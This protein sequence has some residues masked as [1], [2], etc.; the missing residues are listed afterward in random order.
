MTDFEKLGLFYLGRVFD[1]DAQRATDDLL[2]YDAADLTTHAL[3]VGMTGSGKTGLG[4]ALLEEAAMD[5][6]P[7]IAI[8]P[9]GDLGNLLLTFPALS[10]GDFRP[11]VDEAAAAREGQ[12]PDQAAMQAATKWTEGLA[13][14]GQSGAR[15]ARL[16]ATADFA[17]YT[18]GHTG[19]RPLALL[20]SLAAPPPALAGDAAAR[21]ER[22]TTAVSGLL[23]LLGL[24]ADPVQSREH[25]LL[26]TILDRAW[27]AGRDLDLPALIAAIQQPDFDRVGVFDLETFY[28]SKDRLGLAMA[29]NHLLASPGFAAW[30]AGE[31]LDIQRLLYTPAG[32]PRLSILSIA[33]LS[34][35]ER[36]FFVTALL[37]ELVA[38]MR[39]QSGTSSLRA[40]LYMDEIAGYFPPSA[41]PP[42]KPPMLTLLK[43]ARAYGIGVVLA[44]Q[45]PVDLDYK[46]LANCGTWFLGRL[47]TE[48][49]K[50]RVIEG[51]ESAGG[52][53]GYDRAKLDTLLSGLG[54]RVFLMRN[55]HENAPVLFQTR[56]TMSYLRGPL[57]LKQLT[58]LAPSAPAPAAPAT[59]APAAATPLPAAPAARP[60]A[61]IGVEQW[62]LRPAAGQTGPFTYRPLLG[63]AGRLH[64]VDAS[65]DVD[66]WMDIGW[67]ADLDPDRQV[68]DWAG[69]TKLESLAKVCDRTPPPAAA[70]T[71]P[72][73]VWSN[74]KML[75]SWQKM[76]ADHLYQTFTLDLPACPALKLTAHAGESEG[77]FRARL[78]LAL[79]E[80]RDAAVIHLRAKYAPK[81]AMIEERIRRAAERVERER[82]QVSQQKMQTAISVGATILGALLGRKTLSTGNIGRATTSMRSASRIGREKEDVARAG[83][84][85][86]V[87]QEQLA[88]LQQEAEAEAARVASDFDAAKLTVERV[89]IRPRKSDIALGAVSLVWAPWSVGA[90]GIPRPAYTV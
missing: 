47:Q 81:L 15:V 71:E 68:A 28:P 36:M 84:N 26:S 43:Q 60:P 69:G 16:R 7:A 80:R 51:L 18:P 32:K 35:A 63:A 31:P 44:T 27:Q 59:P 72:P 70:F 33:H 66:T 2:M 37:N 90:D 24:E 55:A 58:A 38:W 76:L 61:A 77:D 49:D 52:A 22:V 13:A 87:L 25:I 19:I 53:G 17:V 5:G 79:R 1:P 40:L 62:Y 86:N 54:R 39:A 89:Q 46:G 67:L 88:A 10:P 14:S 85:L 8:D 6:I 83:E 21:G 20:R 82:A 57:T 30:T 34:D 50:A 45:N 48:R 78:D 75:A 9:K 65:A 29:L 11:W 3:C 23:S 56:W 64:F 73:S 74:V 41:V 42:S 4:I 12:T